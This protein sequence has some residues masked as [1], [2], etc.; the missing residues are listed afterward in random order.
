[1]GPGRWL[2]CRQLIFHPALSVKHLLYAKCWAEWSHEARHPRTAP[3]MGKNR[4]SWLEPH[5]VW[6]RAWQ[7]P[8]S[9]HTSLTCCLE[10]GCR[11]LR[12][13]CSSSMRFRQ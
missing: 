12:Y 1:M 2:G 9:R 13:P 11:Q 8:R 6:S 7:S 10:L 5:V 4:C 3:T